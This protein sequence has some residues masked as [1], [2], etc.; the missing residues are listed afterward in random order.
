MDEYLNPLE[1]M[2]GSGH[3]FITIESYE[4]DHICDLFLKLSRRNKTPYYIAQPDEAMHRLG[5][6]H[7]AIPKTTLAKDLMAYIIAS[8]HYGIYILRNYSEI[9]EDRTLI[10]NIIKI[11][12]DDAHKVVVMIDE[13]INLPEKLKP[14]AV[15]SKHQTKEIK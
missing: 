6:P 9:F 11:V 10:E 8:D 3:R 7:I 1:K 5:A 14:Y 13:N 15:L 12:L 4:V 2:L